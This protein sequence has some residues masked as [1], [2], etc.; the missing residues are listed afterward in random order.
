MVAWID[1]AVQ[2]D[3]AGSNGTRRDL[4]ARIPFVDVG[5]PRQREAIIGRA[6][7]VTRDRIDLAQRIGVVPR[8]VIGVDLARDQQ[9]AFAESDWRDAE[10][11]LIAKA[12]GCN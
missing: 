10:N 6:L 1:F 9:R 4:V 5:H 7:A 2:A 8:A 12:A 3:L 11:P